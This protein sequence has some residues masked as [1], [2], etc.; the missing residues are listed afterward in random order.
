V[1]L[2]LLAGF[3]RYGREAWYMLWYG[4]ELMWHDSW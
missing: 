2:L 1:R 3:E 4:T